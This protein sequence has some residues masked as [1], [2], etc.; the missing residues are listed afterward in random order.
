MLFVEPDGMMH[1]VI[2]FSLGGRRLRFRFLLFALLSL[3]FL[4][5]DEWERKEMLWSK[6]NRNIIRNYE[7]TRQDYIFISKDKWEKNN[8][9]DHKSTTKTTQTDR[10]MQIDVIR[11]TGRQTQT[12]RHRQ[13][14][15]QTERH[16]QANKHKQKESQTQTD[17]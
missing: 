12:E 8:K 16:R 4:Q 5:S 9:S 7:S 11:E 17:R 13:V 1:V 2:V 15:R 3:L 14:D 10:D 6:T